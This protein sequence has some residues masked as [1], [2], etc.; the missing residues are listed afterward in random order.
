[1]YWTLYNGTCLYEAIIIDCQTTRVP[2][3]IHLLEPGPWFN[4]NMSSYQYRK[5]HCRDKT[6]VRSSY[7]HN[8]ISYTGKMSSLYWI[9][10]LE[11]V[12]LLLC[13][14]SPLSAE[15]WALFQYQ[16]PWYWIQL[17]AIITLSNI[18]RYNCSK[19]G[20][21]S[22]KF[23]ST[24]DTPYL[25]IKGSYGVSYGNILQKIN[26]VIMAPYCM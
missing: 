11:S 13:I 22:I 25:A 16:Q 7:L 10:A 21:I 20:R 3:W 1:M 4:I 6:V 26:H 14:Y 12:S 2:C 15:T 18:A 17:S 5:S 23:E 19:W 24:K 9:R 8:G